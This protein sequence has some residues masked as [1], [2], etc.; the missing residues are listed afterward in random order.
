MFR[1]GGGV[2]N[3]IKNRAFALTLGFL[4]GTT[5]SIAIATHIHPA[6]TGALKDRFAL[7]PAFKQCTDPTG[8][9]GSP[10]SAASC[11][12]TSTSAESAN[13]TTGAGGVFKL[14]SSYAVE[15]YCTDGST[16]PCPAAGDQET[17]K[18]TANATDVRC[19]SSIA[20]NETLCP[21]ANSAG[22]KDYAGQLQGNATIRI[23]DHYNTAGSAPCSSTTSCSAT[24]VDLPFPATMTCAATPGDPTVGGTCAVVTGECLEC[25]DPTPEGKKMNVELGQVVVNDGGTDGLATTS[26]NT[27]FLR[28]GIYIP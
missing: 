23:T 5:A 8:T 2:M 3:P 26:P 15:V 12:T 17:I 28:Q 13:L 20:S 24:V 10:L 1:R 9:H 22:G 6:D 19:K 4:L 16:P 21:S 27:P 18:V 25:P 7:V 11:K 14:R